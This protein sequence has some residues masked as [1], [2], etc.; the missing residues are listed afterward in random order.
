MNLIDEAL[1]RLTVLGARM[2]MADAAYRADKMVSNGAFS[3]NIKQDSPISKDLL[4]PKTR[5]QEI[6]K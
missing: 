6:Q 4:P 3:I 5:L 1:L 2:D